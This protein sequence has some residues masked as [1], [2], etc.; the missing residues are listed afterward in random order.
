MAAPFLIPSPT[1]STFGGQVPYPI[2]PPSPVYNPGISPYV[3]QGLN[4]IYPTYPQNGPRVYPIPTAGVAGGALLPYQQPYYPGTT[5]ASTVAPTMSVST[6]TTL[7]VQPYRSQPQMI[8]PYQQL[9]AALYGRGYGRFY[10]RSSYRKRWGRSY[11]D[12]DDDSD[13]FCG[14]GNGR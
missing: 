3:S 10:P 14:C 5:L 6:P 8:V 4:G 1:V 7:A 13:C 11:Y 2:V 9:P 12:D